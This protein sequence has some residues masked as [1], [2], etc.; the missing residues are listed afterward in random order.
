MWAMGMQSALLMTFF[1]RLNLAIQA[2]VIASIDGLLIEEEEKTN[3]FRVGA[4]MEKSS[5][6]LVIGEPFLF[7]R[8]AI[9]PLM[10]ANPLIWWKTHEG[11][12]PN[13]NFF[14]K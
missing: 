13:V 2:K 14:V 4:S 12:F 5:W 8:L 1:E 7:Q 11:Q 10:C 6:A 9:P 3:M